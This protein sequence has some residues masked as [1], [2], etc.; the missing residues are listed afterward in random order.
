M[1]GFLLGAGEAQVGATEGR[2]DEATDQGKQV[3]TWLQES[4]WW[5]QYNKEAN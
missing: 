4:D 3:D 2:E 1:I 5:S